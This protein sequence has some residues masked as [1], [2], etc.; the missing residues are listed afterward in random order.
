MVG[1]PE[2]ESRDLLGRVFA[3]SVRP[4]HVHTHRWQ[5]HDLVF[6][7]NRT[8]IHFAEVVPPPAR[9]TLYRTTIEGDV[10]R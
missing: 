7:D 8:T 6:R 4:E 9:R 1:L 3:H 2:D 10:P 5:P